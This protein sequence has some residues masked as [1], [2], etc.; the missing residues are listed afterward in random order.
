MTSPATVERQGVER[1]GAG[2]PARRV[3]S[4]VVTGVGV[5][6]PNGLGR[7]AYW[8]ATCDGI[9]AIAPV[10]RFDSTPY[11]ARLAGEIKDFDLAKHVPG[12]LI[13]QTDWLTRF[14][15]FATAEAFD[16][17]GVDPDDLPDYTAGVVT[18][19]ASGAVELGQRELSA[20]WSQGSQYVSA[21]LSFAWFYAVNTGQI[22][23]RHGL[24]GP[25]TVIV[26][27]GAGGLDALAHARRLIRDAGPARLMVVGGM[28]GSLCPWTWV[29]MLRSGR[30]STRD[31]PAVAYLPF[32]DGACGHVPAEG[33]AIMILE[34][35]ESAAARGASC[36]AEVCGYGTAFD[37]RPGS[38]RAPALHR[39]A[40]RALADAGLTPADVDVVFADAAAVP[41]LDAAEA[42]TLAAL[43]GSDGPPVTAPKTMTGRL[44]S[45]AAALDVA[46]AVLSLRDGLI[47]PTVNVTRPAARY[48]ID[49]VTGQA[50]RAELRTALV[51]ARGYLGFNA[52]MILRRP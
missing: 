21:Y 1:Q 44:Q 18:A 50:R 7:A 27:E 4:V 31:D 42:A 48:P 17:A 3:G 33:G 29:S 22:S 5:A 6:A 52:A 28:D 32:C 8:A 51:L 35:A 23:I 34:A 20:L 26:T 11:P 16:D 12:R 14:A 15:L 25:S 38:D 43:F 36:Y 10:T 13:P 49:L 30:M 19:A 45:G 37:G 24:R 40:E 41:A 46:T 9:S 47:P 2:L 39:A